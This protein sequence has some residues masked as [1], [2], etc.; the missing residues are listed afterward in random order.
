[1]NGSD[2]TVPG[3]IDSS[4]KSFKCKEEGEKGEKYSKIISCTLQGGFTHAIVSLVTC[5]VSCFCF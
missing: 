4:F 3:S 1:M 5:L 2:G